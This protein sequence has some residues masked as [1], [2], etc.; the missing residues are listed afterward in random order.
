MISPKT[1]DKVTIKMVVADDPSVAVPD[2]SAIRERHVPKHAS[3]QAFWFID[4]SRCLDRLHFSVD[5]FAV[6]D[7]A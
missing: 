7:L 1:P 2:L 3:V 4:D 5:I 6:T